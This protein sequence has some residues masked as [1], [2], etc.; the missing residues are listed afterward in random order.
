MTR[1]VLGNAGRRLDLEHEGPNPECCQSAI[2]TADRRRALLT[3]AA[4][5]SAVV[6]FSSNSKL[7]I[8]LSRFVRAQSMAA[9][10][11]PAGCPDHIRN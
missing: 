4:S 8:G 9:D 6:A 5:I 1:R 2:S 7:F 10:S 3:I 11:G